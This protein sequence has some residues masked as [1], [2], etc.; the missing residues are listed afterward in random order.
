[1]SFLHVT[2]PRLRLGT[3][4]GSRLALPCPVIRNASTSAK[5]KDK[6]PASRRDK[7]RGPSRSLRYHRIKRER[8][9]KQTLES[10]DVAKKI[11]ELTE[12]HR[13]GARPRVE[14]YV[15]LLSRVNDAQQAQEIFDL[16]IKTGA[17]NLTYGGNIFSYAIEVFCQHDEWQKCLDALDVLD[18]RTI[19][20]PTQTDWN[21]IIECLAANNQLTKA[22]EIAVRAKATSP[23]PFKLEPE[24]A[25]QLLGAYKLTADPTKRAGLLDSMRTLGLATDRHT[26]TQ[27]IDTFMKRGDT[28]QAV[29]LFEKM[30]VEGY[31]PNEVTF[32]ALIDGYLKDK[33]IDRALETYTVMRKLGVKPNVV[34][35]NILA[36]GLIKAGRSQDAWDLLSR[37][38]GDGVEPDTITYNLLINEF[39]NQVYSPP[40]PPPHHFSLF[41]PL[42]NLLFHLPLYSYDEQ[43]NIT[44]EN[45]RLI[46]ASTG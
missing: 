3:R 21:S 19:K 41:L 6:K 46:N 16:A 18:A 43:F 8:A 45:M 13:R 12:D 22:V 26:Y 34:T 37:M 29:E 4:L 40:L 10:A 14:P 15:L 24:L 27:L 20:A 2:P 28:E 17:V 25:S 30:K 33:Q 1:M 44:T 5:R 7:S 9:S 36:D 38:E 23:T 42:F 35:Y 39:T 31:R 11:K 32:S